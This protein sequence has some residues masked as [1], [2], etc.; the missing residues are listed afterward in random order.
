MKGGQRHLARQIVIKGLFW[1]QQRP[2]CNPEEVI[3]YLINNDD[4]KKLPETDFTTRAFHGALQKVA[5]IDPLIAEFAPNWPLEKIAK[6]D[7][8]I[9]RLGTYELL[10]NDEIPPLV[11]INEAVELAKEFGGEKSSQ[12]IN[13]VLS[14][15]GKSKIGGDKL[16]SD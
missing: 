8:V 2:E 13:G 14:K 10:F 5:E 16:K 9:L 12:F 1:M 15:M 11:A 7:L 4:G 6:I 3:D